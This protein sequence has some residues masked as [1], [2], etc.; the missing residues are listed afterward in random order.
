MIFSG[1]ATRM[2]FDFPGAATRLN[3]VRTLNFFFKKNLDLGINHGNS[4]GTGL[5][6]RGG[7]KILVKRG[8]RHGPPV[9]DGQRLLR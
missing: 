4:H 2:K 3:F 9:K 8:T 7:G 6:S 5:N 1:A